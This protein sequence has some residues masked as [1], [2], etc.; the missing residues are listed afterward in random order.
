MTLGDDSTRRAIASALA[1]AGTPVEEI[2]AA[3]AARRF[4]GI[5]P[6]GPVL[7]EPSSGVLAADACL[8]ALQQAGRFALRTACRVTALRDTPTCVTVHTA[9]GDALAADVVVDC[10][11]T[12]TLGLLGATL[13]SGAG[14]SLPQVAYFAPAARRGA[15][16]DLHRMGR[17]HGLRAAGPRRWTPCRD[18]QGVVP[19]ARPGRTVVRPD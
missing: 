5:E 7:V 2:P 10:A 14:A 18:L 8:E 12:A 6:T 19:H 1:A 9:A 11:G 13:A 4:P 17:R 3:E 15:A 16:A